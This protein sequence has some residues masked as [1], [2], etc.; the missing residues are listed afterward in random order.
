MQKYKVVDLL[1]GFLN[2]LVDVLATPVD[3]IFLNPMFAVTDFS[4]ISISNF[5]KIETIRV[6]MTFLSLSEI[7]QSIGS[8]FMGS[9][10]HLY[11]PVRRHLFYLGGVARWTI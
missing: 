8:L 4:V 11:C 1:H 10:Q 6:P 9:V 7:E 3:G 5:S 2:S